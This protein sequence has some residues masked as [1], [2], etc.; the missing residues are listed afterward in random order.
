MKI[1]KYLTPFKLKKPILVGSGKDGAFDKEAVDCPFVFRH[2]GRFYMTYVGYDGLGYETALAVSDDLIEWTPLGVILGKKDDGSWDST[3]IAG[4]WI[5]KDDDSLFGFNKIKK[6]NGCYWLAYQAYPGEGYEYGAGNIG[7]AWSDDENLLKWHTLSEPILRCEDGE[8]WEKGGLYK[9]CIVENNSRFYLFYNAKNKT[10]NGWN[11]Q[12]GLSVSDDLFNWKRYPGNPV[13]R[14]DPESWD[15]VFCCDPTIYRDGD[16]WIMYYYGF[17]G[18][19]A[20]NGIAFSKDMKVWIKYPFPILRNGRSGE[21]DEKHAHKP[22]LIYN[23]GI[24]YQFYCACRP[25]RE[26]D[27]TKIFGD[28]FR[29]L[30]VALSRLG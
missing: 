23:D 26:G 15:S 8:P 21:L 4:T 29:C 13:M 22:S 30:S 19:H 27:N 16:M 6:I 10:F 2:G 28:E 3:G 9:A 20:Q 17:D 12:T 7:L 11:E 5:I 1:E 25:W 18:K 24:L 14:V